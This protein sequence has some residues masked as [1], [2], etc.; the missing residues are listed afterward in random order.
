LLKQ[1]AAPFLVSGS[2]SASRCCCL[3][4]LPTQLEAGGYHQLTPNRSRARH[5]HGAD[6]DLAGGNME[7]TNPLES[8][9]ALSC[10]T[11]GAAGRVGC[12]NPQEIN[13]TTGLQLSFKSARHR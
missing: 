6:V 2:G 5:E 9:L 12:P 4:V 8:E 11:P 1:A 7:V 13:I 3:T 10:K